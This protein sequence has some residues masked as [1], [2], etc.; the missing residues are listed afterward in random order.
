VEVAIAVFE[1]SRL[2]F[3]AASAAYR[4]AT[5][6]TSQT[7]FDL[8]ENYSVYRPN[9][10]D[11]LLQK[12]YANCDNKYC[13]CGSYYEDQNSY[14][15]DSDVPS[16][17]NQSLLVYDGAPSKKVYLKPR[18]KV[19]KKDPVKVEQDRILRSKRD[20]RIP[21]FDNQSAVVSTFT[22]AD[23]RE[24]KGRSLQS[25]LSDSRLDVA[26]SLGTDKVVSFYDYCLLRRYWKVHMTM[27]YMYFQCPL[28][29]LSSKQLLTRFGP[30][31]VVPQQL[32]DF[33][34]RKRFSERYF[35]SLF[36]VYARLPLQCE[37][38]DFP[39]LESHIDLLAFADEL[40]P[41][42]PPS[43]VSSLPELDR[44]EC[45]ENQSLIMADS[46]IE[47]PTFSG[48]NLGDCFRLVVPPEG[49]KFRYGDSIYHL[50]NKK[51]DAFY[52][53][54]LNFSFLRKSSML[55]KKQFSIIAQFVI[56][57][58]DFSFSKSDGKVTTDIV[59]QKAFSA[60]CVSLSDDSL[61]G[62]IIQQHYR[63]DFY[64]YLDEPI[65][66]SFGKRLLSLFTIFISF[67]LVQYIGR[68]ITLRFLWHHFVL[69]LVLLR[70]LGNNST[71]L[72]FENQSEVGPDD[73]TPVVSSPSVSASVPNY[74]SRVV[75]DPNL[76]YDKKRP[77]TLKSGQSYTFSPAGGVRVPVASDRTDSVVCTMP[78][79]LNPGNHDPNKGNEIHGKW[80]SY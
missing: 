23:F 22:V 43:S 47:F 77:V 55:T 78:K 46:Y 63:P 29:K 34:G 72:V 44:V 15:D 67:T 68:V 33:L 26:L 3:E 66:P 76:S 21:V 18:T 37:V 57:E 32:K 31:T 6:F 79:G 36:D 60:E 10:S 8:S 24:I 16:F 50:H 1:I 9:M 73:V 17:D 65:I 59:V 58:P 2:A 80:G 13:G 64:S 42:T 40:E 12:H 53:T 75:T 41:S 71:C 45:F 56:D 7:Q 62:Q 52:K 51:D 35:M 39:I 74:S 27:C 4:F 25:V 70:T 5:M 11:V 54:K 38:L 20:L 48:D 61:V 49:L 69:H 14:S 28:R 30:T 19:V